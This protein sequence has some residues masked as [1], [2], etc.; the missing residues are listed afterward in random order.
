MSGYDCA[1]EDRVMKQPMP[2]TQVDT[3]FKWRMASG[4]YIKPA[5][6]ETR[7]LF[8]TLVL[9]WNN[10]MPEEVRVRKSGHWT[11]HNR[12]FGSAYSAAYL[13]RAVPALAAELWTRV[14][15]QPVWEATLDVMAT[16]VLA[17]RIDK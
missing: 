15:L 5:N 1:R 4:T 2:Y 11:H 17:R 3:N 7:H 16:H 8:M 12:P 14:D 9:I 6:M 10:V 13:R